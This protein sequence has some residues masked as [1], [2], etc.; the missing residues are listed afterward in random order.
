MPRN[1]NKECQID[2][3]RFVPDKG[4]APYRLPE[5]ARTAVA[6]ITE[7]T[8][9][10]DLCQRHVYRIREMGI[11][12]VLTAIVGW[13]GHKIGQRS[14]C[15]SYFRHKWDRSTEFTPEGSLKIVCERCGA[16]RNPAMKWFG[17]GG[18]PEYLDRLII[19]GSAADAAG[20]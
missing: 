14:R 19:E 16:E 1:P 7:G 11:Q 18:K 17:M 8:K 5:C 2:E 6:F 13:T 3:I 12:N 20:A 9:R 15:F 10:V 4:G